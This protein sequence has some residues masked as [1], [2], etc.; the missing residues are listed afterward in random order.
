MDT[1]KVL[2]KNPASIAGAA[3]LIAGESQMLSKE[4][5]PEGAQ[6]YSDA[7]LNAKKVWDGLFFRL[8]WWDRDGPSEEEGQGKYFKLDSM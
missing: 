6:W 8:G 5:L 7:E 3:S 4:V 1:R 2:P